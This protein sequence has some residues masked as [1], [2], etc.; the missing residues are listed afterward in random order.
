MVSRNISKPLAAGASR[1]AVRAWHRPLLGGLGLLGAAGLAGWLWW[2]GAAPRALAD[3]A[4]PP[5]ATLTAGERRAAG[6]VPPSATVADLPLTAQAGPPPQ[7]PD[8]PPPPGLSAEQWQA[9][10]ASLAGHPQREAELARITALMGF[11]HDVAR[12]RA[13]RRDGH[14]TPE[15]LALAQ[16]VQA[17]L[18]A[19]LAAREI[20][21]ADAQALQAAALD[22]LQPDAGRRAEQLAQWRAALAAAQPAEAPDA[23]EL[24]FQRGQVAL[25][26][27][28]QAEPAAQRDPAQ[29]QGRIEALRQSLF[30]APAAR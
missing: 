20:S 2:P 28:W 13:L 18:P 16:R 12:L 19:R 17:G 11:R 30:E 6:P 1:Q 10:Q 3:A 8:A 26:A 9:L 27:A 29:L 23:R 7:A 14:A 24:A 5:D 25:L 22:V 4:L 15:A 21:A